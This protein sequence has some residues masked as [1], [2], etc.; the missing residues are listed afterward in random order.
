[1]AKHPKPEEIV[2]KLRQA[3]VLISQGQS[4]ADA[5]RALG[6]SSVTYYR[7]RREFG[8]LKSDQVRRMKDL[9]TE[10]T[11]LRKAIADLT[12][13]KLIL[14]EASRGRVSSPARRRACVEHIMLTMNVSERCACRALGQH[15]STQRK[16]PRGRDDEEALTADLVALAET[17]GRYGYRKISALLKA[18]GWFVN[19]KR[20]ERIWRREGLKVPAKQPKRGRIW[21]NDGSCIRLRPEHRNHVWSYDFV[22]ARTHDGRKFR[23]INV[24]DEFT[25]ECLAI[26]VARKLK[27]IDVIDVLSDLFILRGVPGHIRSDNG[28][29]FVAKAVQGWITGVGAKTAYIT[30][31]SP[32]EN[33]YVESFNARLRDEL[34]NGE[35]FYTLREAQVVIESWRRHYNTVRPHASLGYRPPAPEVFMPAFSAWPAALA[36]PAPPAKLPVAERPTVH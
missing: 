1:M 6:V 3:D 23:M 5:I 9:E 10:N 14:Q 8:G 35:I 7:W 29:E 26:R 16:V 21:D 4:V 15:R 31:G 34:L 30:P 33:G 24:V 17:Y 28:P 2:A 13:D 12:L 22:E 18:A 20:V 19:D 11:R 36:R 32:W 27:A 25:H